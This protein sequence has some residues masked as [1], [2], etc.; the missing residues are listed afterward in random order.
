MN[1]NLQNN[2]NELYIASEWRIYNRDEEKA[3]YRLEST[4]SEFL[5]QI[6]SIKLMDEN[7]LGF[8]KSNKNKWMA[9]TLGRTTG[10]G[11]SGQSKSIK[12]KYFDNL[13]AALFWCDINLINIGF[14]INSPFL[15][16]DLLSDD[17]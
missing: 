4:G 15:Y 6:S 3:Y 8:N 1:D 17:I 12:Y 16:G 7:D 2:S 13:L 9:N 5:G 14:K 10:L 11:S